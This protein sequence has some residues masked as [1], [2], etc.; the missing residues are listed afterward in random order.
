[1]YYE[2]HGRVDPDAPPVLFLHGLGASATD[3]TEQIPAFGP[4]CRMLLVDLPGHYRSALPPGRLTVEG[5]AADVERLLAH[6]GEPPLQA[7]GSRSAPASPSRSPSA[8]PGA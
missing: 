3:W 5:M 6:L 8:L 4:R 7:I 2:R 1:M